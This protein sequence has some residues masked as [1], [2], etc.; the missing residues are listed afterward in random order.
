[1][2]YHKNLHTNIDKVVTIKFDNNM[3]IYFNIKANEKNY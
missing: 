1:M 2:N 3:S